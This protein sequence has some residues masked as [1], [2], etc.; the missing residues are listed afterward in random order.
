MIRFDS[1]R[2][3]VWQA[4]DY[5]RT[6]ETDVLLYR[7]TGITVKPMPKFSGYSHCAL[8]D[9]RGIPTAGGSQISAT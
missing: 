2:I 9:W 3:M 6:G 4:A 7:Q 1:I 8:S 5:R